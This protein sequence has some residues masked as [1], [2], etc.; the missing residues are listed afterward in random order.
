MTYPSGIVFTL[1]VREVVQLDN[2]TAEDYEVWR[3]LDNK[4]SPCLLGASV[5]IEKRRR[6]AYCLNGGDYRRRRFPEEPCRCTEDDKMCDYGFRQIG[7]GENKTC[8][9]NR[10]KI[11]K[12]E[13]RQRKGLTP[14]RD[15]VDRLVH[16]E[17]PIRRRKGCKAHRARRHMSRRG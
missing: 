17:R 2:C 6:H 13:V 11:P 12:C 8:N 10:H 3:P 15:I 1:D 14:K 16:R 9:A 4:K 7:T 5:R